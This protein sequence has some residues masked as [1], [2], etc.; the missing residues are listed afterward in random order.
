ME[1]SART[2]TEAD[3]PALDILATAAIEELSALRGG[4]VW[5][6]QQARPV[7]PIDSLR[8]DLEDPSAHVVA[9]TIDGAAV[10]YGVVRVEELPD[11][12]RLGVISDLFTLEG[13]R[14]VSVG[15][16]VMD[17]LIGWAT[18]QGCFG[19]DSLALPG[20]RHTK[21]FFESFGLVARAIVVHRPIG[22]DR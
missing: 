15:E 12:S 20:D 7:P 13:A 9:G 8:A 17:A 10:G 19:V 21:N 18:E 11:G 14:E 4:E 3:L 16:L 2:A 1:V 5:R 22:G 6:R